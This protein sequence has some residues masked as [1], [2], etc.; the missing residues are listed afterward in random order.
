MQR[1]GDG[2]VWRAQ[3]GGKE[4]RKRGGNLSNLAFIVHR[5]S[6]EGG[7]GRG[8][9]GGE[10]G[11]G[12]GLD[13][14]CVCVEKEGRKGE[15]SLEKEEEGR[16]EDGKKVLPTLVRSPPCHWERPTKAP[17]FL[18]PFPPSAVCSSSGGGVVVL[19]YYTTSPLF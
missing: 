15:L 7:R 13:L 4:G 5:L 10:G 8:A 1:A 6:A 18:P 19:H 3:E 11:R 9:G 12:A 14:C 16:K 17:S 2:R